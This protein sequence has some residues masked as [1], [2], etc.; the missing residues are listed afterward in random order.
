MAFGSV[1][2]GPQ[3]GH[4]EPTDRVIERGDVI[5]IDWGASYG[6]YCADVQRMADDMRKVADDLGA[7]VGQ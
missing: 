4:S 6:G 7:L 5:R 3:R 1:V 2:V